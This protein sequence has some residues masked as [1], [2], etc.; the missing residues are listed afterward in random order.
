MKQF[1]LV[2]KSKMPMK[3]GLIIFGHYFKIPFTVVSVTLDYFLGPVHLISPLEGQSGGTQT[4][5]KFKISRQENKTLENFN[6]PVHLISTQECQIGGMQ[7]AQKS[8]IS[9]Q[10]KNSG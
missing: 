7:T 6:T 3:Q 2:Q 1:L 4:A 5:Q 9:R 10:K 8:E